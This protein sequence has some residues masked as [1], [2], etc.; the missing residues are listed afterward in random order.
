MP[1]RR[2]QPMEAGSSWTPRPPGC[3]RASTRRLGRRRPPARP[4]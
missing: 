4:A 1:T 2:S 3:A